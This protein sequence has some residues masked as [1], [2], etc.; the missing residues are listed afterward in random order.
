MQG[1]A[2]C[3]AMKVLE[4]GTTYSWGLPDV[5][6]EQAT[7]ELGLKKKKAVRTYITE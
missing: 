4:K 2:N 3:I 5:F 7:F 6:I 1:D